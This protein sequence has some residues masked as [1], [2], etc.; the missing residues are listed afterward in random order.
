MTSNKVR[1]FVFH[2]SSHLA[3]LSP[4]TS[5]QVFVFAHKHVKSKVACWT[6]CGQC[7]KRVV[8]L[9]RQGLSFKSLLLLPLVVV[10]AVVVVVFLPGKSLVREACAL[11]KHSKLSREFETITVAVYLIFRL[12]LSIVN[13]CC[14]ML[15]VASVVVVVVFLLLTAA[16]TGSSLSGTKLNITRLTD[17]IRKMLSTDRARKISHQIAISLL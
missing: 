1:P 14:L 8:A 6:G 5:G 9:V 12:N 13:N 4:E 10:V 2:I 15:T 7:L 16:A 17:L 3:R 11:V